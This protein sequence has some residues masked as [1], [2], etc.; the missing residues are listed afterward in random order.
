MNSIYLPCIIIVYG[1]MNDSYRGKERYRGHVLDIGFR[2]GREVLDREVDLHFDV[3]S[4][5]VEGLEG[6][7]LML[8]FLLTKV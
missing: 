5:D 7:V 8:L 4:I 1:W 6:I 3:V 2:K